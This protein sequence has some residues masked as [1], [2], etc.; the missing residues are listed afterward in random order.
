V[1]RP[2]PVLTIWV[3]D[4]YFEHEKV[5]E[6]RAKGHDVRLMPRDSSPNAPDLILHPAA[7]YWDDEMWD[8]LPAALVAARKRR[9]KK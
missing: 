5:S 6:L 4:E 3:A 7:H 9:K 2:S 1:G 8:Y